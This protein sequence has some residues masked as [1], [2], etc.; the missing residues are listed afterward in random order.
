MALLHYLWSWDVERI[1]SLEMVVTSTATGAFTVTISEGVLVHCLR[2]PFGTTVTDTWDLTDFEPSS[3][4]VALEDAINA[5][6]AETD[7]QVRYLPGSGYALY[8][9]GSTFALTFSTQGDAG[10]R[11]RRVLGFSGDVI[12]FD[13]VSAPWVGEV[14]SPVQ[15]RS[16]VRPIYQIIPAIEGRSKVS[17][18]Y[19]PD[20]IVDE[21]VADDGSAFQISKDTNEIWLDWVQESET[22]EEHTGSFDAGTPTHRR[23]ETTEVPWSYQEAWEHAK[24]GQPPFIVADQLDQE[25]EEIAVHTLRAEGLSFK[26][27][28]FAAQDTPLF[29]LA[30]RTRLLGRP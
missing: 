3:F 9:N 16:D 6:H 13:M 5:E 21:A 14:G 26:P 7:L 19:E 23:F 22:N 8:W 11:M 24:G 17:D 10:E 30:F 27:T 25:N 18:E 1:G 20:G 15:H 29:S 28:R 2:G 4:A 12:A